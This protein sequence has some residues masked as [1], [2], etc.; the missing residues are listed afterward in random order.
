MSAQWD[1]TA[2][3]SG[4]AA[5]GWGYPVHPQ[6]AWHPLSCPVCR[7]AWGL[8]WCSAWSA[9]QHLRMRD[10][11]CAAVIA[12]VASTLMPASDLIGWNVFPG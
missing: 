1:I 2:R 10:F 4:F 11:Q 7:R 6:Q 9:L 5:V 8:M 12:E 3:S